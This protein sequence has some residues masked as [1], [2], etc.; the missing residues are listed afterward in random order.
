MKKMTFMFSG[1]LLLVTMLGLLFFVGAIYDAEKKQK[2]ETFFFEPIEASRDRIK[3]PISADDMPDNYLRNMLITR[4]LNEYFYVIPDTNNAKARADWHNVDGTPTALVGLAGRRSVITKW[5]ETEA[6]K[7]IELAEDGALR[8]VHVDTENITESESGHLVV[9]YTLTTWTKPNDVLAAPEV[10]SGNIYLE[11]TRDPIRVQST[12]KTLD[13]L[14]RGVDPVAA[15]S[16][17]ILDV[18]EN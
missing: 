6:K 11:V 9:P 12:Q 3:T 10:W 2:I 4:F 15:F 1:I 5:T 13:R 14:E 8:F 17:R 16:F 7:I 18:I